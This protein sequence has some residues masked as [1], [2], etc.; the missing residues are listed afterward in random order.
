MT[1][2]QLAQLI[3]DAGFTTFVPNDW[4]VLV[5]LNRPVSCFEVEQVLP[6]AI[7]QQTRLTRL[8]RTVRITLDH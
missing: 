7:R 6:A 3:R 5:G 4:E 2:A 1:A 8:S